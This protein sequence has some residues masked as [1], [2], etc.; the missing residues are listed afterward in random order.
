MCSIDAW[1]PDKC[2]WTP[3]LM[4]VM[5]YS[6]S[7]AVKQWKMQRNNVPFLVATVTFTMLT[8]ILLRWRTGWFWEIQSQLLDSLQ[9]DDITRGVCKWSNFDSKFCHSSDS[10]YYFW[11]HRV[12]K[13]RWGLGARIPKEAVL[14]EWWNHTAS[15]S[16]PQWKLTL[17]YTILSDWMKRC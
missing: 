9:L 11:M 4:E 17:S 13:N 16:G 10:G 1:I 8:Q 15:H 14:C 6:I 2:I 3:P 12:S 7:N 5:S